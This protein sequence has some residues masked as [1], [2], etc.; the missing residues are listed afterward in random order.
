[1]IFLEYTSNYIY[2]KSA[3]NYYYYY[4]IL[5]L[6]FFTK[7]IAKANYIT[8][9]IIIFLHGLCRLTCPGIDELPSFPGAFAIPSS[10]AFV[11]LVLSILSRWLIQFCL[12]LSLKSCIPEIS[13]SFVMSSLLTLSSLVYPVALLRKRISAVSRRVMS[14][15][16]VNHV[17]LP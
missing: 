8:I 3:S 1:M 4:L 14:L 13:S 6:F 17:S 16:V 10:P 2:R 5:I 7:V 11:G 12:Y 9:I 15:C